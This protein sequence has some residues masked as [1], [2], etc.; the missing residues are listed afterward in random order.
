MS[1]AVKKAGVEFYAKVETNSD[2]AG[3]AATFSASYIKDAD[4]VQTAIAAAFTE[5]ANVPGLYKVPVTI[6]ATGDYTLV[7]NNATAGM[8]NHPFPI[9][10]TNASIDDVNTAIAAVQTTADAINLE[11]AGLNG[12][13]L[14]QLT[15]D[16]A[17]VSALIADGNAS[18]AAT[19]VIDFVTQIEAALVGGASSL[20]VLSGY[21]DDIENMLN[22]TQF[23]ADGV[24]ANP[25]YDVT[26]PGAAKEATVISSLNTITAAITSA[27]D[28]VT[29]AITTQTGTLQTDI[30]AVQT[31][32]DANATAIASN[33]TDIAAVNALIVTADAAVDTLAARFNNG[34][35]IE[36]RFDNI[37]TAVASVTTD[38]SSLLA[39]MTTRFDTVDATLATIDG[40]VDN[41]SGAQTFSVI[42]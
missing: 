16:I 12:D 23:L 42:V 32:V 24:T 29:A 5:D 31:V 18:G 27:R 37:D 20:S 4:G 39:S 25:F 35:D 7:I 28:T 26:N 30:A 11:V 22:G 10:V 14:T 9:V 40:K 2:F 1:Y 41:I 36:V 38:I 21:T 34:G 8:D 13:T 33:G 3:Q 19:T 17:A 6:P 15:T